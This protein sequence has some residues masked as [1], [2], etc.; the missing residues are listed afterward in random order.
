MRI[1]NAHN[2]TFT[3]ESLELLGISR[4]AVASVAEL[5][6]KAAAPL[7]DLLTSSLPLLARARVAATAIR[8]A[9]ASLR[10]RLLATA[11]AA[12]A[13][14]ALATTG[15]VVRFVHDISPVGC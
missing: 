2:M 13:G 9:R 7:I 10:G 8:T 6:G 14:A 11:L 5:R 15:L 12:R 4:G 1:D 3:R